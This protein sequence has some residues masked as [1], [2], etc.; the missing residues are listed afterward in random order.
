MFESQ[1]LTLLVPSFLLSVVAVATSAASRPSAPTPA[2]EFIHTIS[3]AQNIA[4]ESFMRDVFDRHADC[5][6]KQALSAAALMAALKE[7][8]APAVLSSGCSEQELFRR[9][10][11]NLSG[12]VDFEECTSHI[13]ACAMCADSFSKVR[14]R[15]S[16]AGR[17]GDAF[18]G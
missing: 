1:V 11:T 5:K 4:D 9:A 7:V 16:V 18:G 10:D 6:S 2:S 3:V 13:C 14:A 17:V 15:S 12:S 8:Q